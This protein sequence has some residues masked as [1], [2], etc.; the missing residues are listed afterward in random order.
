M[1]AE[2]TWAELVALADTLGREAAVMGPGNALPTA[3]LAALRQPTLVLT[4]G[5]SPTWMTRAGEAVA[6]TIPGAVF[7]V[8][9]GQSHGVAAA[10]LASELLEFFTTLDVAAP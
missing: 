9:A 1:R 2:P 6:A 4:G 3:R 8:L 5:A 10:P 7:R